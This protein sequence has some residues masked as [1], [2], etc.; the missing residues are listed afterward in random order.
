VIEP[1]KSGGD[2]ASLVWYTRNVWF[3]IGPHGNGR[4]MEA[5]VLSFVYPDGAFLHKRCL[6]HSGNSPVQCQREGASRVLSV[7]VYV[8]RLLEN[9]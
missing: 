3:S 5:K 7:G 4:V 8:F 6:L 2:G 1:P 9:A